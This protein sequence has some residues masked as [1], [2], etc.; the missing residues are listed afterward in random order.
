MRKLSKQNLISLD[1][2]NNFVFLT[3]FISLI[4]TSIFIFKFFEQTAKNLIR[5]KFL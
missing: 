4:L 5:S 1:F 2:K 3:Y